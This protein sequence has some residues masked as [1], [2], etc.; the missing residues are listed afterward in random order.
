MGYKIT[1]LTVSIHRDG[2][3]AV[4]GDSAIHVSVDDEAAG[5]F[6]VIKSIAYATGLNAL[7][8][9]ID[10]LPIIQKVAEKLIAEYIQ[11][12]NEPAIVEK[13]SEEIF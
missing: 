2:D 12:G 11:N 5:G 1:P 3:N 10:E 13:S 6:I 8:V 9:D 4:F 7:R